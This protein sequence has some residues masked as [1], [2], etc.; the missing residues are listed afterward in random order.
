MKACR[1]ETAPT[2]FWAKVQGG[3]VSECWE[4]HGTLIDGY[5]SFTLSTCSVRAH[6]VSYEMLVGPIPEGL[7]LDHLCR[8]RRCVNPW[9]LEP[10][11]QLVNIRRG[12][13][14]R[15]TDEHCAKGHAWSAET[16]SVQGHHRR[17]CHQCQRERSVV[18][19]AIRRLAVAS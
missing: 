13:N 6:R 9:H 18:R 2:R 16:W 10:V 8:N 12:A 3:D 4:W 14:C 5:G 1:E 17:V 11:P 7:Q 15:A 19:R